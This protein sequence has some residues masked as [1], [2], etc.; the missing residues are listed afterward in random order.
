[1]RPKIKEKKWAEDE[2]NEH[3]LQMSFSAFELTL[4][5]DP[6]WW[7]R[8]QIASG[9]R[10]VSGASGV[11]GYDFSHWDL[12]PLYTYANVPIDFNVMLVLTV[13]GQSQSRVMTI[14]CEWISWIHGSQWPQSKQTG[15]RGPA[16][17]SLLMLHN[18][19]RD[20]PYCIDW[21]WYV[22]GTWRKHVCLEKYVH[23]TTRG[24]RCSVYSRVPSGLSSHF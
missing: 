2:A 10:S 9:S 16:L 4:C 17:A 3:L 21:E 11:Q 24:Q 22:V 19:G 18:R 23:L 6:S 13:V 15:G 20:A 5:A 1:M 14:G 8:S 7:I 12:P